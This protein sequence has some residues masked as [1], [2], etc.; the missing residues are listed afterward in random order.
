M[1]MPADLLMYD[2]SLQLYYHTPLENQVPV[3]KNR[4]I[5]TPIFKWSQTPK[6]L[7]ER[8]KK[9]RSVLNTNKFKLTKDWSRRRPSIV[10]ALRLSEWECVFNFRFIVMLHK[11]PPLVWCQSENGMSCVAWCI[12]AL[13]PTHSTTTTTVMTSTLLSE[14]TN[15]LQMPSNLPTM[16]IERRCVVK[17]L[18]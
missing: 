13:W 14:T 12:C 4:H 6:S 7:Q 5:V 18:L 9:A 16:H 11:H 10:N 3:Q 15:V 2:I 17:R 1:P 8:K